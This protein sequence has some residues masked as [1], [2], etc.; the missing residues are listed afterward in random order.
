MDI[1]KLG[2]ISEDLDLIVGG[3][4]RNLDRLVKAGFPVP[5]GFVVTCQSYQHFIESCELKDKIKQVYQSK[6][7]STLK[8]HYKFIQ[9]RIKQSKIPLALANKIISNYNSLSSQAVAV[10]SSGAS[11][12]SHNSSF[13]GQFETYLNITNEQEL[14]NSILQCWASFWSE[15]AL[16]YRTS[17]EINSDS[18]GIAIV[19]QTMVESQISGVIF[20]Q[21]PVTENRHELLIESSWGLGE[22]IVSGKTMTDAFV[23]DSQQQSILERTINYKLNMCVFDSE[24]GIREIKV[25][26][27]QRSIKTLTDAQ[28]IE[29]AN[30]GLKVREVYQSEQDIEWGFDGKKFHL[31]QTRPIT[32]INNLQEGTKNDIYNPYLFTCLD[33][34]ESFTGVF[35]PLGESFAKYYLKHT[36]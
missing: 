14:L 6:Q 22:A 35:T 9:N 20:T 8:S 25:P 15:R 10:R 27:K 17:Q 32:T 31:L 36:H 13:A 3:K 12:D 16:T 11:E 26:E 7:L 18:E 19:V 34:G 5:E 21:N 28:V 24:L 29:L 4:A 33:I 1:I 2:N 30:L 23:V